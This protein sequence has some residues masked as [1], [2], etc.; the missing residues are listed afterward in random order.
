MSLTGDEKYGLVAQ[1]A[2][3]L[4]SNEPETIVAVLQRVGERKAQDALITELEA[5]RWRALAKTCKHVAAGLDRANAPRRAQEASQTLD[6][7]A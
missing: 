7:G 4:E 1:L 5:D 3:L 2:L 6:A